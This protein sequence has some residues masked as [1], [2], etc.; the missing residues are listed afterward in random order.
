MPWELCE[1][2]IQG[3]AA[4]SSRVHLRVKVVREGTFQPQVLVSKGNSRLSTLLVDNPVHD[5][6]FPAVWAFTHAASLCLAKN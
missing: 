5:G 1:A 2:A 3:R 6:P 4:G